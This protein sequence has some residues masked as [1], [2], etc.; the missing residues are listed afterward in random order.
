MEVVIIVVF[1]FIIVPIIE[2]KIDGMFKRKC[3][4]CGQVKKGVR[5]KQIYIQHLDYPMPT[6]TNIYDYYCDECSHFHIFIIPEVDNCGIEEAKR[7]TKL[8][9]TKNEFEKKFNYGL[10]K[11]EAKRE[12]EEFEA[13]IKA[14]I[15]AE[16]DAYFDY[17]MM[18]DTSFDDDDYDTVG[19]EDF[20]EYNVHDCDD[21]MDSYDDW[22]LK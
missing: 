4:C 2:Y 6:P 18:N 19:P 3:R 9:N 15:E 20:P 21:D 1:V 5:K 17:L 13:E 10:T 12:Q 22:R 8:L 7:I 14:E 11:E 16:K